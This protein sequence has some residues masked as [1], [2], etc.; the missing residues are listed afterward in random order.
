MLKFLHVSLFL[1]VFYISDSQD[2]WFSSTRSTQIVPLCKSV[3]VN[4]ITLT[5]N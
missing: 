1:H 4:K 3:D 2:I 5:L